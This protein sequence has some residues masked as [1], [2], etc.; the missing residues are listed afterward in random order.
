MML[1]NECDYLVSTLTNGSLFSLAMKEGDFKDKYI[2]N[3]G[4]Y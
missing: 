1:L 3:L 4:K 2:F